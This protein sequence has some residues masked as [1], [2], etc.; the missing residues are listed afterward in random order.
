MMITPEYCLTMARYNAWQNKQ[1]KAAFQALG[2]KELGKDRKAFFGSI[3]ATANHV[4]WGDRLWLSRFTGVPAPAGAIAEST[5]LTDSGAQW[6]VERFRTDGALIQWAER[7]RAV[8]LSGPLSWHSVILGREIS[9]PKA[10]CVLHLF[11]H[12]THHR[13]QIHAML[14][15]A[16]AEAPVSDLAFMPE[17]GPWL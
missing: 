6:A 13:G 7:L 4:L 3:L 14:T 16:G 8:E 5:G 17:E 2:D 15:A 1:L 10:L 12:Q 11:N 9:K